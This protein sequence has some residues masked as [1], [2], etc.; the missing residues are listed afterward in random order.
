MEGSMV[1]MGFLKGHHHQ[2]EAV[3]VR[4]PRKRLQRARLSAALIRVKQGLRGIARRSSA[5]LAEQN[6]RALLN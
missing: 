4:T 1:L 5:T 2:T 6:R 3:V